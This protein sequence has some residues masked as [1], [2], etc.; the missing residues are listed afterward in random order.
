MNFQGKISPSMRNIKQKL[1]DSSPF[2]VNTMKNYRKDLDLILFCFKFAKT[3]LVYYL[4]M[5]KLL[6]ALSLLMMSVSMNAQSVAK[7]DDGKFN[8]YCELTGYNT[9]GFGKLKV[10][11]DMGYSTKNENSIYGED[12][13]KVKFNSMMEVLDY[14]G[15]RGWK[16]VNTYY[17]TMT[18]KANVV[19]YVMEKRVSSDKEKTEGLIIKPED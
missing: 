2:F 11:L 5:K 19:H 12:G 17:I 9:F 10:M 3:N 15:K 4:I 18:G 8:V 6:F 1:S 14:M 16:L 7:T 13:N